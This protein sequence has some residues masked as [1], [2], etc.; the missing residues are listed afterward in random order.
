MK[1]K[2]RK[3][4]TKIKAL[5]DRQEATEYTHELRIRKQALQMEVSGLRANQRG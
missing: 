1:N 3:Y 2:Q 4:H 5:E